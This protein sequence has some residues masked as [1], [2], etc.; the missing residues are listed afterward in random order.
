[1]K[2]L[3]DIEGIIEDLAS[4]PEL[5]EGSPCPL[6]QYPGKGCTTGCPI[7]RARDYMRQKKLRE[8]AR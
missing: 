8:D 4:W 2:T 1:M 3:G 5:P 7:E 6:C